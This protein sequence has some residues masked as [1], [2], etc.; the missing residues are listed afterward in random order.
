MLKM[1]NHA[2]V[3]QLKGASKRYAKPEETVKLE[4]TAKDPDGNNLTYKWWQYAD[5]DSARSTVTIGHAN[6]LDQASVVAPNEPGKQIHLILEV[7]DNGTP[8]LTGYQRI[9]CDIR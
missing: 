2:P 7:T 4:A 1:P 9:I 6:S 3:T 5:A 8:Q